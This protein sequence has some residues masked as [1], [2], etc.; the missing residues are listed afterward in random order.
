MVKEKLKEN[1]RRLQTAHNP[2][3][4]SYIKI[5]LKVYNIARKQGIF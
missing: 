5:H 3:I 1:R 2:Q 4:K